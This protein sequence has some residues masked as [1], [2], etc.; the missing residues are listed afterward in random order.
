[1]V[2]KEKKHVVTFAA[3]KSEMKMIE[4]I[5]KTLRRKTYTDTIRVLIMKESEKIL[6]QNIGTAIR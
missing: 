2:K 6:S 4:L 5:R 3:T 1:M